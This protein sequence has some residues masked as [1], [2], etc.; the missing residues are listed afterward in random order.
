MET[1]SITKP[2]SNFLSRNLARWLDNPVIKKE[3]RGRMRDRRTFILLTFYLFLLAGFIGMVYLVIGE[4][5][6]PTNFD[7]DFRQ[8]LGKSI[9]GTVI[10]IELLLVG[11]IA[12]GLTSGAITTER[13]HRTLDLLKTTLITPTELVLGKLSS[14]I[15]YLFLLILTALPLQS[16]AFLLGGVGPAEFFIASLFLI[17][18]AIFFSALGI[19]FSSALKRTLAA[20]IASYGSILLSVFVVIAFLFGLSVSLGALYG[21]QTSAIN[22]N[23]FVIVMWLIISTNPL[24][25]PIFTEII[26][27]ETQNLYIVNSSS[28]LSMANLW[29]PSPWIIYVIVYTLAAILLTIL[30]VQLIKRPER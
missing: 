24:L 12:P 21:N 25:A 11:F 4:A 15:A 17:V 13:E 18:T 2:K 19:F 28:G 16:V 1:Q 7:P 10:I 20:T 6:S 29:L 30:S 9:F 23:I 5:N 22:E 27:S 8:N 14:S 3:L 26:L